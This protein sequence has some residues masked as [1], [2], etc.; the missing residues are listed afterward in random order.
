[1]PTDT[2]IIRGIQSAGRYDA[3]VGSEEDARRLLRQ[4]MPEAVELP[5]AV[6]RGVL[7]RAHPPVAGSGISDIP[8][9]RMW[10]MIGR[11]SNM[12]TGRTARKG[13]AAVGDISSSESGRAGAG[14]MSYMFEVLYRGPADPPRETALTQQVSELGGHLDYREEPAGAMAGSV[15]LTYEFDDRRRAEAAA[16]AL[17]RQGEHVEGPMD[18]G[19]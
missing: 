12:Q 9:N 7:I 2:E 17:R 19:P 8:P 16:A 5:A 14:V 1:M 3:S 13:T 15:C 11:T 4:A 10:G 18:Y 6:W